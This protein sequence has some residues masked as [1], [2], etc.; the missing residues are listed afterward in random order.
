M[1]K[2]LHLAVAAGL[3]CLAVM[4]LTFAT[5]CSKIPNGGVPIYLQVDSPSVAYDGGAFGSASSRIPDVWLQT[6]STDLG[7]YEMPNKIPI[8]AQGD[9]PI[10]VSGGIYDNGIISSRASY[11][12]YESD[13]FTIHNATPGQLYHFHP[14][15]HYFPST[16]FAVKQDFTNSAG[17]SNMTLSN[18]DA[19]SSVY[20]GLHSGLIAMGTADTVVY[21]LY[22]GVAITTN[23]REAYLEMNFKKSNTSETMPF[24]VGLRATSSTGSITDFP[25]IT[26][27][28]QLYWKKTYLNFSTFVGNNQGSTFQI[29]IIVYKNPGTTGS[30]Y[31]D[32]VKLLYFN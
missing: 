13:T 5:G 28:P 4:V 26:I 3:S 22:P 7:A 12:F 21:S 23:G 2:E 29:Y 18:P 6:G 8:L 25:L 11:P 19:D 1:T 9:V 15:Y 17:F 10:L 14:V 24:D 16:Q 31:F 20:E 32:N 27:F 30:V